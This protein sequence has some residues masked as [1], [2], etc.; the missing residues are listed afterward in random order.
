M[1]ET[2]WPHFLIVNQHGENRG[3]ESAMRAM[4][5]GLEQALGPARYTAVV[6]Y[7]DTSL[8][9]PFRE[10]VT[11]LQ[12]RMPLPEMAGLFAF[13]AL[14]RLGIA[15][16]SLLSARTRPIVE[17]YERA[18]MVISAPGGPY[19]GDIYADHEIVHWFYVWLATVYRKPLFLYAPSVG[20]FAIR[21]LNPVRRRLFRRFD[22]LCVREGISGR[23]L[24]AL[25]GRGREV[26]VTADAAIQQ[27]VAPR[28]RAD[29]FGGER[30]ALA[31]RYLVAV[32]AIEYRFPEDAD[33]AARQRAY[34]DALVQCLQH[35]ATRKGCHFLFIPQLYGGAHDDSPYLRALA[36]R[37]PEGA[38]W[39]ISCSATNSCRGTAR[40]FAAFCG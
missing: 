10:S 17:A 1:D 35:L 29:Y 37:L 34:G 23:Y 26:H 13:G 15:M 16:R 20:P 12:L 27:E 7:R 2:R 24:E 28:R 33:P 25:L 5:D 38:R 30:A 36:A 21:W 19:F 40:R 31:A 18:D 14:R 6:Q 8:T 39:R 32:S 9:V 11:L 22:V 3:D 4:I